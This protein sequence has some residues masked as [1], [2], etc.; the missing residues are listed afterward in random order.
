ML[1]SGVLFFQFI[2]E[3]SVSSIS[4]LSNV[5]RKLVFYFRQVGSPLLRDLV[6]SNLW[7]DCQSQITVNF[8]TFFFCCYFKSLYYSM[9]MGKCT[10]CFCVIKTYTLLLP[11]AFEWCPLI[12]NKS[13]LHWLQIAAM[14]LRDFGLDF[15]CRI[16]FSMFIMECEWTV[17]FLLNSKSFS[18]K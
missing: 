18:I 11:G 1:N 9:T 5:K 10:N 7:V 14:A 17:G 8:G 3:A 6:P 2:S 4:R 12:L 13:F 16:C 15:P